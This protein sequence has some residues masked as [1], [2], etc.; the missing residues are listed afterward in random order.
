MAENDLKFLKQD[1]LT[2]GKFLLK[3]LAYPYEYFIRIGDYQKPVDKLKKDD[4]FS[5]MKNK[6]PDDA[7][8]ERTKEINEKFNNK[9]GEE[10][11][12]I[13]LKSAVICLHVCLR[14]L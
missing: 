9:D 2:N 10:V 14:N 3:K 5:K 8:I 1:F 7:E 4:F 12:E 11:T 13:F 6:C